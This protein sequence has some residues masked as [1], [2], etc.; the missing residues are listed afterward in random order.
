MFLDAVIIHNLS[1]CLIKFYFFTIC[2]REA[3]FDDQS[4]TNF[5]DLA[6]VA[7]ILKEQVQ[8][9]CPIMYFGHI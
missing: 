7:F 3:V 1:K 5:L 8:Y 2:Y 4:N 6:V 9:A